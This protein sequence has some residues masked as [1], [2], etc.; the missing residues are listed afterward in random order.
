MFP[1][2]P[3]CASSSHAP[4]SVSLKGPPPDVLVNAGLSLPLPATAVVAPPGPTPAVIVAI[5]SAAGVTLRDSKRTPTPAQARIR[6]TAKDSGARTQ[7]SGRING[8][9][10][11]QGGGRLVVLVCVLVGHCCIVAG[12]W[13]ISHHT[14]GLVVSDT[15]VYTADACRQTDL[16]RLKGNIF[17]YLYPNSKKFLRVCLPHNRFYVGFLM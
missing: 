1:R 10:D 11:S 17:W 12:S 7:G 2:A 3:D 4:L 15:S 14:T 13:V 8:G 5:I 16:C 6:S 9:G